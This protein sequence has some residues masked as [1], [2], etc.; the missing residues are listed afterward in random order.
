MLNLFSSPTITNCTFSGNSAT[1]AGGGMYS[2]GASSPLITN[3]IMWGDTAP[4]DP[5]IA[6]VGS[7][8]FAAY[9]DIEG[10]CAA[11]GSFCGAGNIDSD[12]FFET[13]QLG[14]FYLNATS[15]CVDAGTGVPT[16]YGL[17]NNTTNTLGIPDLGTVDMG[18]HYPVP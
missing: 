10:G 16:D 18:Y 9:S 15:P 1:L 5:E 13:G 6:S 8:P 7:Q 14:D 3:C 4:L 11:S 17:E 12:P 2:E